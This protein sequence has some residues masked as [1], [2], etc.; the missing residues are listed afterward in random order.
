ML[1]HRVALIWFFYYHFV[2]AQGPYPDG[3][4]IYPPNLDDGDTN[5]PYFKV[6]SQIT[7]QWNTTY[8]HSNVYFSQFGNDGQ[9]QQ[10]SSKFSA[11]SHS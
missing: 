5:Y 3:S 8:N 4:F 2:N 9:S 10:I 1:A 7:L 11:F 6:G